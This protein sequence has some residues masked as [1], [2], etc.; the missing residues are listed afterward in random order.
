MQYNPV[1]NDVNSPM[2]ART[3]DV[4]PTLSSIQLGSGAEGSHPINSLVMNRVVAML[5]IQKCVYTY[6]YNTKDW[7]LRENIAKQ[8]FIVF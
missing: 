7:I 5:S 6:I 8:D 3:V 1:F 2:V 4:D